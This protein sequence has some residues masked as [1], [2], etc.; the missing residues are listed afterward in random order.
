MSLRFAMVTDT[1]VGMTGASVERLRPVYAAIARR[2]PDFV[3]H[4]GDITDTGLPGEYERYWQTVPAALRGRIRHVPGNH[5]VRWDPTAKG[6]YREQF[7]AA[8]YSFDAGGVH[9]TGLDLTQ[10]LLEPGHCGAAALEWLDRDLAAAGGP[11]LLFQHFPVGGEHD[12]VDDQAALLELIARHDVR[13]LV[14]GHVHR[15]TVTRLDGP[16]Q[17]TLQA[18]LKEPVFYWAE[19]SD[20]PALTVSRVTV[21]ADGTQASSPVAAV[22]LTGPLTGPADWA[23]AGHRP[24]RAEPA[25]GRAAAA[26]VAAAAARVRAGRDHRGRRRPGSLAGGIVAGDAVAGD[27]VVAASTSGDVAAVRVPADRG[28]RSVSWLWRARFGPVYRRPGVSRDGRTLFVPSADRH[29]YALDAS[30]GLVGWRFAADAPVLSQPLVTPELVVFTAGERLLAV[31]ATS[32]ELAWAVPGRGFSAG[33]AG[34]DGERV[35]TAAADGF[36]RAHD[37][38]TGREAW[39]HRMVSGDL[40]RVTLYSGWDDVI[41]LGAGVVLAATVSGTQALEA[42][43][44]APRWTLPGSTMYPPTVVLG[45]GTALFATERGL[46][47]RVGLA[48]GGAVW[49]ADL[50][51]GV[52]NAGLAVAG[53]S[54]WV[55]TADGRLVRVRLA[56]GRE[57]GAVRYTLAQCFSAPAVTGDTLVAGD[58]DGVVHG[59][60]LPA[61]RGRLLGGAGN[62]A[63]SGLNVGDPQ[64]GVGLVPAVDGHQVRRQ[65][66]DLAAVAQAA[67]VDAA[68]AGDARRQGL[69]QVGGFAVVAEHQDVQVDRVDLGIEQQDRGDVVERRHHPAAG[70]QRGGLLGRTPLGDRQRVGAALVEAERVHA[71]HDDLARQLIGQRGQQVT[72]ALPRHRGDYHAGAAGGVGVGQALDAVPDLPRGGGGAFGASGPDDHLVPGQRESAGQAASLVPG[73]AEDADD[74]SVHGRGF[75]LSH[76]LH[77]SSP[78]SPGGPRGEGGRVAPREQGG[79]GG[80]SPRNNTA[81]GYGCAEG[82]SRCTID[83]WTRTK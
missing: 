13:V 20:G 44:G 70:Q 5:E 62:P 37:L 77:P 4:C 9:V 40:H 71:V 42:A 57:Q 16:V 75:A 45:D 52:Q 1:H 18:V 80:S 73:A 60:R 64:A 25:R 23:A 55:V 48:D 3:L 15:E 66:L 81:Y 30:T 12:Y 53:D 68:H 17:V 56:D 69:H 43:T 83:T 2:A 41:A 65:R 29:L 59:L 35:Y 54:A 63:R 7:G 76:G 47:S 49:Q 34:C 36:A 61:D 24:R 22:P 10:P 78:G 14:A 74:E 6:L 38:R 51:V 21:A 58:Q 33:R 11:A 72:V 19:L 8:P 32:G 50:G 67:G 26:A 79:L 39:S 28:D 27:V 31:H 46:L 82:S